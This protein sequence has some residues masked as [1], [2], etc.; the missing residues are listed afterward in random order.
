MLSRLTLSL[1]M[2]NKM[3]DEVV[4]NAIR[5][6]ISPI[7]VVVL[8]AAAHV[9]VQKRMDNCPPVGPSSFA[10]SKAYT[11]VAMKCSSRAFRDKYTT[12]PEGGKTIVSSVA[13]CSLGWQCRQFHAL[14]TT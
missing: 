7:T 2:A 5:N 11:C 4:M 12:F 9:I 13:L 8:D 10:Y 6:Q 3:A 14:S 1:E